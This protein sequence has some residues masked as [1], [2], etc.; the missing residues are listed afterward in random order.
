MGPA[1][2]ISRVTSPHTRT[3]HARRETCHFSLVSCVVFLPRVSDAGHRIRVMRRLGGV[4]KESPL[5]FCNFKKKIG[6]KNKKWECFQRVLLSFCEE[7]M[8]SCFGNSVEVSFKY[9]S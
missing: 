6:K 1:V 8:S 2:A 5:N 4:V 3:H 7:V 9:N